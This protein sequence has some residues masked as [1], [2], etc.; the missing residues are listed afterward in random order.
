[1]PALPA[2][3]RR[4]SRE[5]LA[6][7]TNYIVV[8]PLRSDNYIR[9]VFPGCF[10][11]VISFVFHF[12]S[13]LSVARQSR[14]LNIEWLLPLARD[15]VFA[16]IFNALP[17]AEGDPRV[18]NS[19]ESRFRRETSALIEDFTSLIQ[20]RILAVLSILD[21]YAI[22]ILA[23]LLINIDSVGR[24]LESSRALPRAD[25]SIPGH[26]KSQSLACLFPPPYHFPSLAVRLPVCASSGSRR[27]EEP[28][29]Y[30]S[31][32]TK[33]KGREAR[34]ICL[35]EATTAV[36]AAC[37]KAPCHSARISHPGKLSNPRATS[38]LA[39]FTVTKTP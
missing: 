19:F 13:T 30:V 38:R 39:T 5:T 18:K 23:R 1:M 37:Q 33:T 15:Y 25:D 16:R 21:L 24:E 9:D 7:G 28:C 14:Y 6:G 27:R 10:F 26:D 8:A 2:I 11:S 31:H 35:R 22:Y 17:P 3:R 12:Q 32:D 36:L 4:C 34:S 29:R 20:S